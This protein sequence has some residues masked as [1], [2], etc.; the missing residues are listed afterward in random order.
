M[1]LK[2]K[3][4]GEEK[5]VEVEADTP[6]LW[7]LRDHFQMT[8]TK[9]GCGIGSCRACTVI[10][11][12]K[13][14][15]SCLMTASVAQNGEVQTI[16][17]MADDKIGQAV[18]NAWIEEQVPQC[19]Y[20]QPGFIVATTALLE[21]NPNPSDEE[22]DQA[23]TNVCRCGTYPRIRQAIHKASAALREGK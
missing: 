5:E 1:Q 19:G 14:V 2:I 12:G 13:S 21:T 17:G 15:P 22:I 11:N 8:G 23:I 4:N 9:F 10:L 7:V 18:Q 16:E 20:C 3:V 6:L